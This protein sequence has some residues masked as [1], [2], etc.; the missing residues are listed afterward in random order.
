VIWVLRA[1]LSPERVIH[2]RVFHRGLDTPGIPLEE[3]EFFGASLMAH[4]F[5]GLVWHA[6]FLLPF[7]Y[8]IFLWTT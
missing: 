1:G 5:I 7:S 4:H 8:S 6:L 3:I 2:D